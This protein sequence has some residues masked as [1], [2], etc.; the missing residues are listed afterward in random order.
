MQAPQERPGAL[1]QAQA[2]AD[3]QFLEGSHQELVVCASDNRRSFVVLIQ[4]HGSATIFHGSGSTS[5]AEGDSFVHARPS[6]VLWHPTHSDSRCTVASGSRVFSLRFQPRSQTAVRLDAQHP[7]TLLLSDW[8]KHLRTFAPVVDAMMMQRL[9]QAFADLAE[10]AIE[11]AN[12][13]S[14]TRRFLA[15]LERAESHLDDPEFDP[16]AL[17]QKCGITLRAL[18]KRFKS[19]KTTPRRWILEKRL[20]RIRRKLHDPSF[21]NLTTQ[22]IAAQCGLQNFS[23]FIHV[24]KRTFGVPPGQ[25]RR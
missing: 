22:K 7:L 12:R 5:V 10:T 17:A 24:F 8:L 23:H 18:Q 1:Q 25:Y 4:I 14:S 6:H 16:P 3:L 19:L 21:R 11:E 9:A 20:E 15:K 2:L 13:S